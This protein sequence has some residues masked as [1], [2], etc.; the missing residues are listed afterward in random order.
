MVC[1][2]NFSAAKSLDIGP[3]YEQ[4]RAHSRPIRLRDRMLSTS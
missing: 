4:L 3:Y 1:V 2:A